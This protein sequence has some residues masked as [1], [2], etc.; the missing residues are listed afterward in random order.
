MCYAWPG[1]YDPRNWGTFTRAGII[2]AY[3]PEADWG[4]GASGT[5]EMAGVFAHELG[6]I[7]DFRAEGAHSQRLSSATVRRQ[8][9]LTNAQGEWIALALAPSQESGLGIH[10]RTANTIPE[11]WADA[12]ASW[13]F[14]SYRGDAGAIWEGY[15]NRYMEAIATDWAIR[16]LDDSALAGNIR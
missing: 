9:G 7:L 14:G 2:V 1:R 4:Y 15:M 10:V 16:L 3:G 12:L 6:H 5:R 11:A 13:S 8:L